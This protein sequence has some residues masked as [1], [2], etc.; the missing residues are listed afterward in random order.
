M[1][2]LDS[3]ALVL[4]AGIGCQWLA[5]RLHIPALIL[6]LACGLILGPVTHL[7]VPTQ[8]FGLILMPAIKLGVAIILFE[9]GLNLHFHELKG[10]AQAIRRLATLSIPVAWLLASAAAHYIGGLGWQ[11]ASLFGAI[12]VVTGPTVILP[13]L[14]HARLRQKPAAL[15]KWEGIVNDPLGAVLAVLVFQWIVHGNTDAVYIARD[16]V[17]LSLAGATGACTGYL[18]GRAFRS[19]QVHEHLKGPVLIATVAVLFVITNHWLEDSG[20]LAVTVMGLVIGN[21][22]LPSMTELRRF[23]EYVTLI[24]VS[25]LFVVL[26]ANINPES[27]QRLDLRSLAL[28][29]AMLFA[30][31]PISVL[32]ATL[33]TELTWKE[34]LLPAWIAPRGIVAAAVAGVF[35]PDLIALGI[36]DAEQLV[37]LIFSLIVV[38][39][40]LHGLTIAPWARLLGLGNDNHH[41]LLVVGASTWSTELCNQLH[42]LGVPVLLVDSSW[43][44][45]RKARLAGIPAY[46]GQILSPGTE[47]SVELAQ[48]DTLLALSDNEAYNALV[49]TALAGEMGWQKVFQLPRSN[50]NGATKL[51]S[52]LHGTN[53]F[54]DELGYE[55][56]L[57]RYYLGWRFQKTQLTGN[58]DH[59][60]R[61]ENL[62]SGAIDLLCIRPT[63][64]I[65][66]ASSQTGLS[67]REGDILIS[68]VPV[69]LTP[70]TTDSQPDASRGVQS[71]KAPTAD[72]R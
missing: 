35:A 26:S 20:L 29:A 33:G 6:L 32:V 12:T 42:K 3:L 68:F 14:R 5:S 60:R 17:W 28:I 63:G 2:P 45:L 69:E 15:L 67:G 18:T 31:R 9:G 43:Q 13:L 8:Q 64:A 39:V 54:S 16:L 23:K 38:T 48:L 21:M 22:Q 55:E 7:L 11:I 50:E 34:R 51:Q 4:A 58:F 59:Q 44:R 53:A 19:G 30:V 56:L 40:V 10:T 37:P 70:P 57:R 52:G 71:A 61:S 36:D 65:S 72:A 62:P 47:N 66:V 25:V 49:C 41:G 1:Q 27:F 24:L 46:Y